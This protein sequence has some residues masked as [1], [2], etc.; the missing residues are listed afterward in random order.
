M[1]GEKVFVLSVENRP[2]TIAA[3]VEA[4]AKAKVNVTSILGWNP[5]GVVQVTTD[6]PA[7]ARQA[8]QSA[9]V[10]FSEADAETAELSNEPG[11][12]HKQ[13]VQ[14]AERGVNIRSICGTH[15]P[16]AS[17]ATLIW[18]SEG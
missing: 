2:G 16:G 14:L 8:L 18:T 15:S 3:A 9:N 10:Q 13:L 1:A 5:A 4:L 12:L 11:T 7:R 6:N 17:K